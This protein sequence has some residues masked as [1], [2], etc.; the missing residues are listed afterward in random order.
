MDN[1]TVV[2]V[3]FTSEDLGPT[4][5]NV[6][7]LSGNDTGVSVDRASG[8]KGTGSAKSSAV[9]KRIDGVFGSDSPIRT[10][11]DQE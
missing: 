1:V 5:E 3:Q 10:I 11:W 4:V 9:G 6:D 8:S 7:I 2:V